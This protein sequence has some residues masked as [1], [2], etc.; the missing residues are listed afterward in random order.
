MTSGRMIQLTQQAIANGL[1]YIG[2]HQTEKDA[3]N[4]ALMQRFGTTKLR[5]IK[6]PVYGKACVY[7]ARIRCHHAI[8][9][10]VD[11]WGKVYSVVKLDK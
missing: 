4:Y 8:R 10:Q 5:E 7:F 3:T 9:F 6:A 2:E 1:D 11:P